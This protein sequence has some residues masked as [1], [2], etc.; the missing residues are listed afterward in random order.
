VIS[1]TRR[2]YVSAFFADGA[3]YILF[4]L[5]PWKALRLGASALEL[6]IIPAISS[7]VYML[8]AL[9]FGRLADRVDRGRLARTGILFE[10]L[11]ILGI[12]LAPTVGWMMLVIGFLGLGMGTFWPTLQAAVGSLGPSDRL[13]RRIGSF[14]IGWSAGKMTGFL[15]G[16]V[17]LARL[18]ETPA[19]LLALSFPLVLFIMVPADL[20]G[21]GAVRRAPDEIAV[22]AQTRRR[23]R[24]VGWVTNFIAFGMGATLNHQYPKLLASAGFTSEDFGAYL[25]IIYLTQTALFLVLSRWR[26]W[27]YRWKLLAASQGLAAAALALLPWLHNLPLIFATG[28]AVG[29]GIGFAYASSIY[30]SLHQEERGGRNT[31]VHESLI[32]TGTLV[33]PFAGG[34]LVMMTGWLGAP[35]LLC[36]G[37]AAAALAVHGLLLRP[38]VVVSP[39]DAYRDPREE[40]A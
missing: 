12:W 23:F 7:S 2:L 3:F 38:P 8:S 5:V 1:K 39:D 18:G 20:P 17:L 21:A 16:G 14:N 29:A 28:L 32:G 6:G 40:G 31:G 4:A 34:A 37:A 9:G 27:V 13:E 19:F 24:R 30:Y 25:A 26:G 36:A 11:V 22:P 33:F 10:V 15:L 35:Y